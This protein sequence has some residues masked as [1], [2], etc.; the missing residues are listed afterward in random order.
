MRKNKAIVACIVATFVAMVAGAKTDAELET[1]LKGMTLEEKV[2]Q[3][4]QLSSSGKTGEKLAEDASGAVLPKD[5]ADWVRK[6]EIGTLLGACG[7]KNYNALQ[8][9][10]VNESRTGIPLM[11]G[12]DM[13]HGVQ[14]Q[15]PI[16][17][18]LAM[19]WDED[20][21]YAA[22]DMI[23][24]ETPTK[25]A[26]WTFTPMVDTSRDGRWGRIAE[27]G[28]Q[29]AYLTSRMAAAMVKGIQRDENPTRV[30]ACMKHYVGYGA[31]IAGRD[32]NAVE[33]SES[34][35]RNF[36]LPPFKA[37][38]DAGAMTVMPAF[39]T[40]NGVPCSASKWLLTDILRG[41]FGFKGFTISDFNA[42]QELV[43]HGVVA[44]GAEATVAAFNAGMDQDMMSGDY[45]AN[46]AAAVRSGKV[47]E[48]DVDRSVMNVLKIKNALHL[49]EKPYID[50]AELAKNVDLEADAALAREVA[51]KTCVLMKNEK[52]AL[53]LKPGVK[54]A[55]I[56]PCTD[57]KAQFNG[58]WAS[59]D[60]NAKNMTLVEGLKADGVDF[61]ACEGYDYEQ[62]NI[63]K[64]G[65]EKTAAAADVIV[66]VF[67]EYTPHSGEGQSRM[68]LELEGRQLE[69]FEIMKQ[70]GKPIVAVVMSGRPLAIPEL[71]EGADAIVEVWSPGTSGGWGIAD[72]L[73]G[74]VNPSARLTVEIPWATGQSPNYYNRTR[75][76]RPAPN[77]RKGYTSRYI[78]GEVASLYPFGYGLSYT[79]FAYA[80]EA[81]ERKGDELVFS[82][83][84]TNSG[85]VDGVETVQVYTR[86]LVARETR[87]IRELR[88]WKRVALK[89][90]E[91][92]HVEIAVPV[93]RLAHW[94][95]PT[96]VEAKGRH[97]GWIAKDSAAGKLLEFSL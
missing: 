34:T 93:A 13:I 43:G 35:L 56:G 8:K 45:R 48:A 72:V 58:T 10:A 92:A 49:F 84:V 64:E 22:G 65:I 6:G 95:G 28:G 42:V 71:A 91:T 96:L 20:V 69:A 39:H 36:Y 94:E 50:E 97:H 89:A 31:A 78:D 62:M 17:L 15:L 40:L 70:T 77:R 59:W 11:V 73:T 75:T 4:V 68:K 54:V 90:G 5:V 25:G 81:V 26:N 74:L 85:K 66:A 79:E 60:D 76:A 9:I 46:L 3:L 19:T 29:D 2:G 87:P 24:R 57:R 82:C 7:I 37:G 86:E 33:M 47:K 38:V 44:D 12:H 32:Y 61:V 23:G 16:P 80:N 1:L 88:G 41:E 55:L 53:P 14:T 63:D 21:W 18:A 52:G 27:S 67:G 51:A 83:D 30:A